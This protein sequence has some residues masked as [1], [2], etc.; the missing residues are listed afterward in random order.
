[1]ASRE[2]L[3]GG[4]AGGMVSTLVCH[5]LDLL[6]IRYSANEGNKSRPQYRSYWHAT[7]SIVKAEG[8]RGLYQG[9]TPN[10]VGAALAWG[11]YFD[12]YYVIKEKCTKH[13]VSTG[14][15]TVDN[16]FFG[17]TSGSCVLALTNPIWVS[18]TRLCL[19]YENEFSKPYSGMFNCIK[20]MALDEGFSSLYKGFVPG[21]FGTI[22][23]ALQFMLYN[24]FKDTHFRRLGVTSEY[25]L[26][27]VDYLLYSAAS[28]IIATT[29]TFPYQLLRTRLQDQHVAYNG[30]W[31]AIVRTARTEGISGFYKG[32]LMANIRQVPAAVVTFVTYENI[33]HLIHKWNSVVA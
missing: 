10:L 23:G 2:H 4:F 32:L 27:T 16:F 13:N 14:A 8:V 21:L 24:Y 5:P 19:Q 26:S 9:L 15:E 6:R 29:V 12:F 20:R 17:L 30:L 33:R 22:H 1:M 11:L 28:K 18:K 7:K 3:V 31:D 25:Q